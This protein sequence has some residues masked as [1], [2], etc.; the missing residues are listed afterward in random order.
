MGVRQ[1]GWGWGRGSILSSHLNAAQG[2]VRLGVGQALGGSV[3]PGGPVLGREAV[4]GC[5]RTRGLEGWCWE[6]AEHTSFNRWPRR[7]QAG[8]DGSKAGR[9]GEM[10]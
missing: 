10:N 7:I 2:S 4:I 6:E 1:T 3:A 8:Q 5:V 9:L